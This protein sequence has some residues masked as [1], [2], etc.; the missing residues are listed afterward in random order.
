MFQLDLKHEKELRE[1]IWKI[2]LVVPDV[3]LTPK[4]RGSTFQ[5]TKALWDQLM[6]DPAFA[7]LP[8]GARDDPWQQYMSFSN[9]LI[10][11]ALNDW[12]DPDKANTMNEAIGK[13]LSGTEADDDDGEKPGKKRKTFNPLDVPS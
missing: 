10:T 2:G 6:L 13:E 12:V 7:G 3:A 8:G 9:A 11:E 4:Q 1:E 5:R